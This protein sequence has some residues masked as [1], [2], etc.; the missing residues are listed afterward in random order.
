MFSLTQMSSS[1]P[2]PGLGGAITLDGRLLCASESAY[3]IAR[4]YFQGAGYLSG[5]HVQRLSKGVNSCLIGRTTDGI[6]LAFRGT[7]GASPL[8]WLQNAAVLLT[9]NPAGDGKVHA[10]FYKAIQ[11]M[12]KDIKESMLQFLKDEQEDKKRWR[13]PKFYLT[14]HSKGGCLA[15]LFALEMLKDKDLPNPY[16]VCSFGAARIGDSAFANYFNR[17]IRQTSY[18]NNLDIIPFLPPGRQTMADMDDEM[19][20]YLEK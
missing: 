9:T 12:R 1:S 20:N 15:S 3:D 17:N 4:P 11:S 2:F 6:V 16:Y 7:Q 14:G 18:E 10:G 8:D 5:T 19:K 13:K